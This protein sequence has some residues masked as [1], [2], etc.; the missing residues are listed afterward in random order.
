MLLEF[1]QS[2]RAGV[3]VSL[4]VS[5]SKSVYATLS[6]ISLRGASGADGAVKRGMGAGGLCHLGESGSSL[7]SDPPSLPAHSPGLDL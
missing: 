7:R 6:L 3:C 2:M 4:S 5:G 1:T